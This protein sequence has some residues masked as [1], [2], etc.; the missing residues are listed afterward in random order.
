MSKDESVEKI[1]FYEKDKTKADLK[2]KLHSD[3]LSQAAFF[4]GVIK[5]YVSEEQ[6][7]MQWLSHFR[8]ENSKIRSLSKHKKTEKLENSGQENLRKFGI[9]TDDVDD[10]FDLIEKEYPEL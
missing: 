1:A 5:A 2:I 7:F 3:G 8:I 10:I 9:T 6:S 4:R